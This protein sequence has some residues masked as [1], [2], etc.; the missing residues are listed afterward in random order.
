M[1]I[2]ATAGSTRR[3]LQNGHTAGRSTFSSNRDSHT[4]VFLGGD[5]GLV[6]ELRRGTGRLGVPACHER[7]RGPTEQK[8]REKRERRSRHDKGHGPG[9]D[10]DAEGRAK[11]ES[12]DETGHGKEHAHHTFDRRE[13]RS[14]D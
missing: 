13:C 4:S 11:H 10:K 12:T 8:D 2:C 1:T 3:L 9:P 7:D 5:F 6:Q 14:E